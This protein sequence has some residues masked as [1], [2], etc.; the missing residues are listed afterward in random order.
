MDYDQ[1]CD[2]VF[3]ECLKLIIVGVIV[4][5]WIIDFEVFVSIVKEVDVVFLVDIVHI[6]GLVV[7]GVHLFFF[8]YVDVVFIIIH[9]MLWGLW[10]GMIMCC[11]EY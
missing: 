7:I 11:E 9:K 8:F 4:Y 3:I 6:V 10:G 5:L 1:I 2:F